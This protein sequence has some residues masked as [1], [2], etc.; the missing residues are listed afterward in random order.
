V[1]PSLQPP[2]SSHHRLTI[3][4]ALAYHELSRTR[5]QDVYRLA[6]EQLRAQLI[7]VQAAARQ[8]DIELDVTFDDA[9]HSQ[10]ELAAPI[11][12][13]LGI[14]ATFFVPAG[15]VGVRRATATWEQLRTLRDAGHTIGSH[16]QTHVLL[17]HCSPAVLRVELLHSRQV[18]EDKLGVPVEA[19]SMPGG[20][21]TPTVAEACRAAGYSELY[22]SE[23]VS[24]PAR[25]LA[26]SS[27][28]LAVVGRLIV[29]RTMPVDTLVR[30]VAGDRRLST[31][32]LAEYR[33]KQAL[34]WIVGDQRYQSVWR[35]LLRS[36]LE[37]SR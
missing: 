13:Q 33:A 15:W 17:T 25:E 1:S 18:L 36:P 20:R 10:V 16:G 35:R 3:R 24:T 14:T 12:E 5:S 2:A 8:A 21:W 37:G 30:Y 29:R 26:R 4:R 22:T 31:R 7:A 23:P 9:H 32:L 19:I 11:L 27:P 6:P 28:S 34:K